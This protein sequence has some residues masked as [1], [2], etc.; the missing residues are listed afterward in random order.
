MNYSKQREEIYEILKENVVH[1]SAEYIYDILKKANSNSSL[2]TVYRN[3]NKRAS[4]GRIKKIEGLE[5]KAHFDHNTYEHYH[6][7]CQKCGRI[8]DIDKEVAPEVVIRAQEKTGFIINSY[9]I[10]FHGICRECIEKEK[11]NDKICM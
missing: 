6:F 3:L 5:E 9:D 1:P 10:V 11:E 7:I 2:A 4:S 8:F